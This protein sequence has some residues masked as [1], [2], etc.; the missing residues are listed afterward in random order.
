MPR[1][2]AALFSI[3]I[4]SIT[5]AGAQAQRGATG[6]NW[7]HYGG[8]H[9]STKYSGLEQIDADNFEELKVLWR[10]QSVDTA[11]EERRSLLGDAEDLPRSDVDNETQRPGGGDIDE[12]LRESQRRLK[13]L[14]S[15]EGRAIQSFLPKA[16]RTAELCRLTEV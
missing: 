5:T 14:G 2:N 11:L 3:V 15:N 6:G 13:D 16:R 1:K 4:L 7:H 8:D 12:A 9:G 10:W